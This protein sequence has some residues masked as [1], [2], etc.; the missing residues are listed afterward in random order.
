SLPDLVGIGFG[1]TNEVNAAVD[2]EFGAPLQVEQT[3]AMYVTVAA[4]GRDI[5]ALPLS[6]VNIH[7][8]ENEV[9]SSADTLS[10]NSTMLSIL[11]LWL[12]LALGL[13]GIALVALGIVRRR[14]V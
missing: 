8:A 4:D 3:Q 10:K 11:G 14:T 6:V 1:S 9:V 13:I 7:T 2:A 12:P 5:P